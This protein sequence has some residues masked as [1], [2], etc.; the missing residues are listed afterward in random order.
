M[1][2]GRRGNQKKEKRPRP[3]QP[4][5][6]TTTGDLGPDQLLAILRD[7]RKTGAK[8]LEDLRRIALARM[9]EREF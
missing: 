6:E 2:R 4:L 7:P 3:R 9:I 5:G 1:A 8:V